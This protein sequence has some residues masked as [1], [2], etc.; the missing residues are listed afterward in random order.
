LKI[1][2]LDTDF[3]FPITR[4]AA[5]FGFSTEE[6]ITS[7]GNARKTGGGGLGNG[8]VR[9]DEMAPLIAS[10]SSNES[11]SS[12]SLSSS[13]SAQGGM[14]K[15]IART[16]T[17]LACAATFA[18]IATMSSSSSR[19]NNNNNNNDYSKYFLNRNPQQ[20]LGAVNGYPTS[21]YSHPENFDMSLFQKKEG[22]D[23]PIFLHIPKSGGTSVESMVG[24]VGGKLGSC[25]SADL[26]GTRP[27]EIDKAW[28]VGHAEDFHSPP[29]MRHL[30]NSFVTVRNPYA[31]AES[32][33]A[34]FRARYFSE[35]PLDR[36][37]SE[38]NCGLFS[39]WVHHAT[40]WVLNSPLL[41][42]YREG[43]Y[44]DDA[45]DQC[46]ES[47][48][49]TDDEIN[50]CCKEKTAQDMIWKDAFAICT[51]Q[52]GA[53]TW[54]HSHHVPA[55][56]IARHA[57][58]VFPL[59]TCL[60]SDADEKC[61]DPRT[62]KMQ[63]N[64][65]KYLQKRVSKKVEYKA[66]NVVNRGSKLGHAVKPSVT[67]CWTDGSIS[68]DDI[69]NFKAAYAIDF[70]KYGYVSKV[71]E[72][73]YDVTP[74]PGLAEYEKVIHA[75]KSSTTKKTTTRS[76]P[77]SSLAT[78][79]RKL[80][81]IAD[82]LSKLFFSEQADTSSSSSSDYSRN[83]KKSSSSTKKNERERDLKP[84]HVSDFQPDLGSMEGWP[85][86]ENWGTDS[87]QLE[88]YPSCPPPDWDSGSAEDAARQILSSSSS[89]PSSS[90]H[91]KHHLHA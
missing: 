31:R 46:N 57:E 38:Q 43:E 9:T 63:D 72:L 59:E 22:R 64:L 52:L 36:G 3:I 16:T 82:S 70:Q 60:V 66:M 23:L 37:Y 81:S 77:S 39:E 73:E 76:S 80:L 5:Q 78:T 11:S 30:P 21:T 28:V 49:P 26:G 87:E 45:M 1:V 62:G 54:H 18:T 83:M 55:Y 12:I 19:T 48:P 50:Q 71:P 47:I 86:V 90:S 20:K 61:M 33:F 4:D 35:T 15:K 53:V 74:Q 85:I 91:H 75:K 6:M 89:S 25:N 29:A 51:D 10:S 79:N 34:W 84:V 41:E 88:F 2:T 13:S 58:Y 67:E 65:V 27:F 7:N 8:G 44:K 56:V 40:R 24:S 14:M 32:E 42:C 69:N 17:A 68:D